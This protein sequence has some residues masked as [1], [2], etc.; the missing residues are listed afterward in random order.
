MTCSTKDGEIT[1]ALLSCF[2]FFFL[3]SS[4]PIPGLYLWQ[5][6]DYHCDGTL[7]LTQLEQRTGGAPLCSLH[8]QRY[9]A[10]VHIVAKTI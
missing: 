1:S 3:P 7:G 2:S 4:N 6:L 5:G 8:S 9:T 10:S